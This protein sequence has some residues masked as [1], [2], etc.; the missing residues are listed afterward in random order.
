MNKI[1]AFSFIAFFTDCDQDK[2]PWFLSLGIIFDFFFYHLWGLNTFLFLVVF[3][4]NSHYQKSLH[5]VSYLAK[6]IL[7]WL[8]IILTY[9]ALTMN[10]SKLYFLW[11]SLIINLGISLILYCTKKKKLHLLIHK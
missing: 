4:I 11:P 7:N 5:L 6:T 2:L 8:I 9:M 3:L 10:F 1:L